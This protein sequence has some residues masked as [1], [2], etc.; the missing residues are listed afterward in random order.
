MS[1]SKAEAFVE[2]VISTNKVE[3]TGPQK[4]V[5]LKVAKKFFDL[6]D[7]AEQEVNNLNLQVNN[8]KSSHR[9]ELRKLDT[10]AFEAEGRAARLQQQLDLIMASRR[11]SMGSRIGG[12]ATRMKR[13]VSDTAKRVKRK[14]SDTGKAARKRKRPSSK[15][16]G[17]TA[18]K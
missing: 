16:A 5:L 14:P 18:R 4:E 3:F 2:N 9:D 15:K 8:L 7:D 10:R 17:C 12:F 11:P 13:K 6:F 1:K